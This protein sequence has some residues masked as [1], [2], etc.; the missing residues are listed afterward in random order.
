V[1]ASLSGVTAIVTRPAHQSA[2]L[3]QRLRA[4]G[5][6]I[7]EFPAL[8][9]EPVDLDADALA[10]LAPDGYDWTV[11]TSANAVERALDL[12][13]VPRRT[14]VAAIGGATARR[15]R[16]HGVEVTAVPAARADSEGLLASPQFTVARGQTVLLLRGRGGRSVLPEQLT[17][18]GALVTIGELY[19]RVAVAPT[20][21]AVAGLRAAL[22]AGSRAVVMAT[23]VETLE[24]ALSGVPAELRDRFASLTLL[25]PGV[26]V[27]A[28]AAG[29]WRGPTHVAASAEDDAMVSALLDARAAG[30]IGNA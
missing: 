4:L 13:P 30:S 25:I 28:A 15:L 19:R 9:I 29:L 6:Q 27:A 11:F 1:S 5:A 7:V 22:S 24:A 21:D 18:R 2:E 14:R 17:R 10:R 23:S 3:V 20:S 26:R 12:W 8:A 16:L